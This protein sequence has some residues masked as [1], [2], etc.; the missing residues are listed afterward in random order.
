MTLL[1]LLILL[2]SGG[3]M[4]ALAA[5]HSD[6]MARWVTFL[7]LIVC[8]VLY[9]PLLF[10]THFINSS[11]IAGNQSQWLDYINLPWIPRFGIHFLLA[12]DGIS[13][14]LIG[15]TLLLGF[16]AL[17][18]AWREIQTKV[19]FFYFNMLWTLAGIIGVFSAL[20]LF[21][22]F[23]FWE[24]ML[25]P[26]FLMINIW[27]QEKRYYA[28]FKFFIYTQVSGLI[29]LL[30]ILA[31]V[32]LHWQ[33]TG[34][35]TFS[36]FD[37][38]HTRTGSTTGMLIMLGFFIAFIVKL[39]GVPFHNWQPDVYAQ[40]PTPGSILLAGIMVKTG[41]YGLLRF[42]FPLFPEAAH[43]FTPVALVIAV[44]SIIYAAKL[45]FA[46][47][48]MK[49]LI[50]YTSISHMGFVVL[51]IFAWNTISLQGTLVQMIA[52]G[53]SSAGM[54]AMA[55]SLQMRLKT[56]DLRELNGL[57]NN[58]PKMGAIGLF[59]AIASL[60][61]PGLGNFIGEFLVLLG[62]FQDHPV[63]AS[64][65]AIGMIVAPIYALTLIQKIFYGK[66]V[67]VRRSPELNARISK[68]HDFTQLELFMMAIMMTG[69][70]LLGFFPRWLTDLVAPALNT[71]QHLS[72]RAFS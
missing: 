49:R 23:S 62:S 8:T 67:N 31:L 10:N 1:W 45:A 6:N 59:F 39:P 34:N 69:L 47:H 40:A 15:L 42:I 58:M 72:L 14:S 28:A 53:L 21:L 11:I 24:I 38:L 60:G 71:L 2:M 36:W 51:G 5:R 54:F 57:W 17:F 41:A 16:I 35:L 56:R 13:V 26:M 64:I 52:H 25:I 66:Q 44:V 65:A 70:I 22:F 61:L 63:F 3:M 7:T 9:L 33:Q 27:G 20:D 30:S 29:M 12:A 18:S 68:V 43:Q 4:A 48:D 19:G 46:Q 50:A 55:G 37:L 32:F